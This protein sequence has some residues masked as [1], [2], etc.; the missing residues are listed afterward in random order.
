MPRDILIPSLPH[1]LRFG[2]DAGRM[3]FP[4]LFAETSDKNVQRKNKKR[5][6][7]NPR[8]LSRA[9]TTHTQKRKTPILFFED[10]MIE[11]IH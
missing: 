11:R 2:A 4:T 7:C 1:S 6:K 9:K 3:R 10:W 5:E 8:S